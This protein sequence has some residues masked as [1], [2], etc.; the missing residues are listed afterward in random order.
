MWK[1][2]KVKAKSFRRDSVFPFEDLEKYFSSSDL[3]ILCCIVYTKMNQICKEKIELARKR[4]HSIVS[5]SHPMALIQ[6]KKSF[7][8]I[9]LWKVL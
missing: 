9:F 4:E 8:G 3:S 7:V 1:M 5:Y 6:S 2:S